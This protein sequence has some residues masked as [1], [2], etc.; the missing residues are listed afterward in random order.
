VQVAAEGLLGD[1]VSSF[2]DHYRIENRKIAEH[3]DTTKTN[4]AVAEW[5]NLNGKFAFSR[6]PRL[7][8]HIWRFI[9][10]RLLQALLV[11][12]KCSFGAQEVEGGYVSCQNDAPIDCPQN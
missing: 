10:D 1:R 5:R 3:S 6:A 4:S 11:S 12:P 2:Y 8:W 7:D 9:D